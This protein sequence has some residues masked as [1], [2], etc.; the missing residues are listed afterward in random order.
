MRS[1]PILFSIL[2]STIILVVAF[3][4]NTENKYN[5][6]VK[7]SYY[8]LSK[9][10]QK[11]ID[12][13]AENIYFE[14]GHESLEG[15]VAVALVTLNRLSTGFYGN[16]I[17]G[18]VKQK[19]NGVCQ[20]SWVCMSKSLTNANKLLYNDIK[21]LAVNIVM[22]YDVI[23]DVTYGATYYHADYVNPQWG[24]PKTTQI[25]RH[26][27]YKHHRDVVNINRELKL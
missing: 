13:L 24:L 22:N 12:C 10:L 27:F 20:F 3:T 8:Q 19:A 25:G 18:V 5:I 1:I 2:I 7:I 15:K 14:A 21:Q 9:P 16:D 6:P 4:S 11:Q 17:C 23:R 26:I